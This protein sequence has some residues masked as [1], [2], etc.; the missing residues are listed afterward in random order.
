MS[1]HDDAVTLRQMLDHVE[2]AVALARAGPAPDGSVFFLALLK[3]VEIVEVGHSDFGH[4][5]GGAPD[6]G[7]CR[8]A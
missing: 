1:R 6:G 2:E 5:S 7:R 8:N 4:W 3:L